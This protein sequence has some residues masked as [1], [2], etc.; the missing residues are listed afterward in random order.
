MHITEYARN[1]YIILMWLIHMKKSSSS[2]LK[3]IVL[4]R[5]SYVAL[6][7][8]LPYFLLQQVLPGS[9]KGRGMTAAHLRLASVRVVVAR[10]CTDLD[11]IYYLLSIIYYLLK[12]RG[13]QAIIFIHID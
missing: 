6:A 9:G 12:I 8:R 10:W 7:R 5:W 13:K 4:L 1:K 3:K 11:V 2:A